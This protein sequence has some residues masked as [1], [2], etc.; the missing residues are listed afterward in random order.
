MHQGHEEG[1]RIALGRTLKEGRLLRILVV[2]YREG[3]GEKPR[4]RAILILKFGPKSRSADH[5]TFA[6]ERTRLM[7]HSRTVNY[8]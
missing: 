1:G 5:L 3:S 7:V 8:I 2:S 6:C 4:S